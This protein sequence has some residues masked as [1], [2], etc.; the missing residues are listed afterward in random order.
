MNI[1]YIIFTCG[2]KW[3]SG[4]RGCCDCTSS[5]FIPSSWI[6]RSRCH[7]DADSPFFS[8]Y[9]E[10]TFSLMV[11]KIPL[12]YSCSPFSF[13]HVFHSL[14]P[15]FSLYAVC[16]LFLLCFAVPEPVNLRFNPSSLVVPPLLGLEAWT[17]STWLCSDVAL[18]CLPRSLSLTFLFLFH[19]FS[20]FTLLTW[21]FL[22][23]LPCMIF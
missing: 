23:F 11:F 2:P 12:H 13:T 17:T 10:A 1:N 22:V 8:T 16:F 19:C 14:S 4:K 20:C 21:L 15:S 18:A 9:I 6:C 5:S 7:H 3:I